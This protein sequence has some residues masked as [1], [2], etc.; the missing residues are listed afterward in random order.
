MKFLKTTAGIIIILIVLFALGYWYLA[1]KS[2]RPNKEMTF[3]ITYSDKFAREL[4]LDVKKTYTDLLD[5]LKVK[6]VR[7]PTYWDEIEYREG[8]Y[9][10]DY[11]DFFMNEAAK[12]DVKVIMVLGRRQPR[13]PECH[14]P[15]WTMAISEQEMPAKEKLFVSETVKRYRENPA[16]EMWQVENEPFLNLFGECLNMPEQ[17][18]KDLV[19]MV[20]G[21]DKKNLVMITASG[22]LSTWFKEIYIGDVFGTTMYRYVYN[23]YIGYWHYWFMPASFY[24]VKAAFWNKPLE[25]AYIAELQAEPWAPGMS[26]AATPLDVQTKTMNAGYFKDNVEYAKRTGFYR[27][28]LW[29]A[30]W[31]Y[32]LK[33][34]KGDASMWQAAVELFSQQ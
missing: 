28:Y 29:G 23:K 10:W 17:N 3:G 5:G 25:T 8:K 27:S 24:R 34:E 6:Y 30:E 13:W 12:R 14:E 1:S 33:N 15:A 26:L 31:W 21:L 18:V 9:N 19:E 7:I 16:L 20:K 22:E 2:Y 4:G 32:W 11:V